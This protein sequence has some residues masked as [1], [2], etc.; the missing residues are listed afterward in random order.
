[1]GGG[2]CSVQGRTRQYALVCI[3]TV[4]GLLFAALFCVFV[5]FHTGAGSGASVGHMLQANP[6][7]GNGGTGHK[8][9][10]VVEA[11]RWLAKRPERAHCATP[12]PPPWLPALFAYS[13]ISDLTVVQLTSFNTP[14]SVALNVSQSSGGDE[15]EIHR[16]QLYLHKRPGSYGV[17]QQL[18]RSH[19][20]QASR[21]HCWPRAVHEAAKRYVVLSC[22]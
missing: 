12:I 10:V 15:L 19:A 11:F 7:V 20:L 17:F 2:R 8:T 21:L 14:G 22:V 16:Q 1:M 9:G 4:L 13:G 18:C 5:E 3:A 6:V